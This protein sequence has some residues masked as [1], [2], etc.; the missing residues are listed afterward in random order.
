[1]RDRKL[2]SPAELFISST[3][4]AST[5]S[6]N[7]NGKMKKEQKRCFLFSSKQLRNPF[8]IVEL[9]PGLE[10]FLRS[11]V[12]STNLDGDHRQIAT[13]YIDKLDQLG[14]PD[15]EQQQQTPFADDQ[16]L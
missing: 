4:M 11:M 9:L 8:N 3:E 2:S 16:S 1:M 13:M 12:N 14:K 6:T 10:S 15:N 5:S 7:V